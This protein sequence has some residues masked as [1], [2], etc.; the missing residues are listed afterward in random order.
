MW[1]RNCCAW[2]YKGK[3]KNLDDAFA[4][5]LRYSIA[6][7]NPPLLIVSDME[8][9]CVHTNW[10]NTVQDIHE[11]SLPQL[12]DGATRDLLKAAFTDPE[13]LKP[14]KTRQALTEE[15][16]EQF[17]GAISTSGHTSGTSR[18]TSPGHESQRTTLSSRA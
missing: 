7:E 10:T 12:L 16:A 4:Q 9:L 15:A 1:R 5:L 17:A 11:F 3:R 14:G 13:R 6:L 2:E 18:S 8:R